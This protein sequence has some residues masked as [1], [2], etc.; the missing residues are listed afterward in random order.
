MKVKR[1]RR[2]PRTTW[3]GQIRK[4]IEMRGEKLIRNT[5][6]QEVGEQRWPKIS[7]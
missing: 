7:L 4:D 2:R 6:K 5:G 1:T 3:I